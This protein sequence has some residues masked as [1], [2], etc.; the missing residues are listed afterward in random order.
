MPGQLLGIITYEIK[1]QWR[2]GSLAAFA[3]LL[4]AVLIG[5]TYFMPITAA[6]DL[7]DPDLAALMERASN[8][9]LVA[10]GAYPMAALL[11]IC[12]LPVLVSGTIPSDRQCGVEPLLAAL[13]VSR[14][15]YLAGKLLAMLALLLAGLLLA[16]GLHGLSGRLLY[17]AYDVG[18][19][20]HVWLVGVLPLALFVGGMSVLLA[21]NQ[22]GRR[23][24]ALVGLLFSAYCAAMVPLGPAWD[25][26]SPS[27]LSYFKEI[28]VGHLDRLQAATMES[29]C[30][31]H[32]EICNQS[33][34]T[35]TAGDLLLGYPAL[36][37]W[38]TLLVSAGQLVGLFIWQA[39]RRK[40]LRS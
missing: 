7:P 9:Y 21:A 26:L 17:G 22:P 29:V 4:L 27:R 33:G 8:T 3:L 37:Q 35:D 20:I 31:A 24:A 16:F 38:I 1:L 40:E 15:V 12:T 32:P 28:Y 34:L 13:P 10:L 30:A 25:A 2:R 6:R 36:P 11:L 23:R 14:G 18:E 19:V 5:G 39:G